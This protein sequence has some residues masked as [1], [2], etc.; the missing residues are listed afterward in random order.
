MASCCRYKSVLCVYDPIV[1]RASL[2]AVAGAFTCSKTNLQKDRNRCVAMTIFLYYYWIR[3]ATIATAA[4]AAL[5]R[6]PRHGRGAAGLLVRGPR[7]G[8]RGH[9]HVRHAARGTRSRTR[10]L[11]VDPD[12]PVSVALSLDPP[13]PAAAR[14]RPRRRRW[15]R[16]RPP[17]AARPRARAARPWRRAPSGKGCLAS[18]KRARRLQAQAAATSLLS[19]ARCQKSSRRALASRGGGSCAGP[20]AELALAPA[21][22]ALAQG[23]LRQRSWPLSGAKRRRP[24]L[25]PAQRPGQPEQPADPRAGEGLRAEAAPAAA[26]ALAGG[27]A[28]RGQGGGAAPR[29]QGGGA[30]GAAEA[31]LAPARRW[32]AAREPWPARP[33][34]AGPRPSPSGG[35]G[36]AGGPW[37]E[38]Y[39]AN[40]DEATHVVALDFGAKRSVLRLL[41]G[42]GAKVTVTPACT[43][44]PLMNCMSSSA[45]LVLFLFL[46]SVTH[47]SRT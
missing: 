35:G 21:L 13:P 26:L 27:A 1:Q 19:L 24:R 23:D 29:G 47:F 10:S 18:A 46:P 28:L 6:R 16:G 44:C 33:A 31:G 14:H 12:P 17:A 43:L 32:L 5:D 38:G 39:G 7:R 45:V 30:A 20:L 36:G 37:S 22:G 4:E 3:V 8:R 41:A 11:A 40:D 9:E 42:L 15:W 34:P 25:A 2:L